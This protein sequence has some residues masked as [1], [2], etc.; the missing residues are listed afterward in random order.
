M[1]GKGGTTPGPLFEVALQPMG[2]SASAWAE[3]LGLL[4]IDN[5]TRVAER[6][7]RWRDARVNL[8]IEQQYLVLSATGTRR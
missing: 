3:L 4:E 8:T 5:A 6:L 7:Q 2:M 1:I